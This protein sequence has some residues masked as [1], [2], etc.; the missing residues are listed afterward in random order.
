M[1][2]KILSGQ[3]RLIVI[4]AGFAFFLVLFFCFIPKNSNWGEVTMINV[5]NLVSVPLYLKI[6]SINV[7]A[8]IESIGL[9]ASG[10]MDV[11][12]NPD[13]VAWYGAG[14]RPGEIGSAVIDGHYGIWENGQAAVFNNLDKL[15]QGDKIFIKDTA[16]ITISFIVRETRIYDPKAD[17][18]AI[19]NS[20]DGKSHLNLITCEGVWNKISKNYPG[21]LVVFADKE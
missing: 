10:A 8:K 19:F 9:T 13:N 11:P 5:N 3:I 6:P 18:S 17:A 15:R 2:L 1:S 20:D 7:D 21:R 14:S 16:G 12:K 4:L